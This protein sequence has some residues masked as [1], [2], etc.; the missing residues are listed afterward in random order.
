MLFMASMLVTAAFS[1]QVIETRFDRTFTEYSDFTQGNDQTSLGLRFTLWKM[2]MLAFQKSPLGQTQH[3]CNTFISD[4][5][6]Q[7]GN[8]NFWALI[9]I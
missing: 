8:E 5:L 6:N 4:Y 2:G 3:E 1:H 9:Y 7:H